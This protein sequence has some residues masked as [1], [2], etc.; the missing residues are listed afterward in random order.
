[1]ERFNGKKR[2]KDKPSYFSLSLSL[3]LL[4]LDM[5]PALSDCLP[6]SNLIEL[7]PGIPEKD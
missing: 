2:D 7:T 4:P 6:V 5:V 3:F 1:M